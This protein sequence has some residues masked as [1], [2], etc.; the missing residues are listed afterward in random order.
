MRPTCPGGHIACKT[1]NED[2]TG[3]EINI[4]GQGDL[5]LYGISGLVQFKLGAALD[6]ISREGRLFA[7]KEGL[8]TREV[9]KGGKRDVWR[10]EW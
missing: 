8:Q 2:G 9:G 3:V 1:Y 5:A 4:V 10:A 7:L 6:G